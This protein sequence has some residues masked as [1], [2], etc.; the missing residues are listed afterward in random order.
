MTVT[1]EVLGTLE[2]RLVERLPLMLDEVGM[3]LREHWPD[4]AD[5]LD[6]DRDSVLEAA[7]VFAPRLLDVTR[8]G[9]RGSPSPREDQSLRV[10]FERVGRRQLQLGSDLTRLL[11]AFQYGSR[12]AWRH[13]SAVALDSYLAP[14]DLAALADAVFGTVNSL[15]F[16][17]ARGY[18]LE[19]L[20][21]AR[22]RE[23]AREEL[24]AM[25]LSGRASV[26]AVRAAAQR[27]GWRVPQTATVALVDP[28]DETARHLIA[29]LGPDALRIPGPARYGAIIP[30]PADNA[31]RLHLRRLLR[32][33]QAVVGAV[34]TLDRLPR[35][36][37][38]AEIAA[39]LCREGVI[40]ADD[41]VFADEHLDTILVWRDRMLIEKLQAQVLAPLDGLSEASRERLVET[42]SCWLRHQG[43]R[44]SMA[45]ELGVHPQTVRYRLGQLRECFGE[46]LDDPRSRARL[47]LA[48]QWG[49]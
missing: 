39:R 8:G 46:Q 37:E 48:L 5:F 4:Y 16:A 24:A 44:R 30:E 23:N 41:P 13:V 38:I 35:S 32:G 9:A 15:S 25:L 45:A 33:A 1:D 42:L 26:P 18:L 43:D 2:E 27:A 40:S 22:A 36:V 19:Q 34:V 12:V 10:I 3:G 11:T 6:R 7:R 21:D 29:G 28:E 47:F 17:A 49:A 20:E 31:G 14:D